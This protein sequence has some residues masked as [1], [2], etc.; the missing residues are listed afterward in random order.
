M[1]HCWTW[2]VAIVVWALPTVA[3]AGPEDVCLNLMRG[4]VRDVENRYSE[5]D[6]F[7]RYQNILKR[8]NFKS[9]K[10]MSG[11]SGSFGLDIPLAKGLLGLSAE[12]ESDDSRFRQEMEQFLSSN[13]EEA[14]SRFVDSVSSSKINEQLLA[15]YDSC[16]KNYFSTLRDRVGLITLVDLNDYSSFTVSIEATIPASIAQG[17]IIRQIEPAARIKC[18]ENG[19]PVDFKTSRP[20]QDALMECTKKPNQRVQFRIRTNAGQSNTLT[21]PAEPVKTAEVAPE[22]PAPPPK[23][24]V[25]W[26]S[27]SAGEKPEIPPPT[28]CS[29]IKGPD[30]E[31]ETPNP[32][33]TN[34]CKGPVEFVGFRYGPTIGNQ[35]TTFT[36][37][38]GQSVTIDM[39]GAQ[40]GGLSGKNCPG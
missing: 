2:L 22:K 17:L 31:D 27:A 7:N 16:Q 32:T 25:V 18:T 34:Q 33:I 37:P 1:R 11:Q 35:K 5:R 6:T 38:A 24:K 9:F 12:A 20:S 19:E 39:A 21:L 23:V 30:E 26:T 8:A 3:H 29:C 4:D 40:G 13:Y 10:E 36:L 28:E 15:V 14:K